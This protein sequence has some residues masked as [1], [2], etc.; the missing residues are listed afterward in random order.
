MGR[1][2]LFAISAA[3][4]RRCLS[5]VYAVHLVGISS[6]STSG[7]VLDLL[8]TLGLEG[9]CLGAASLS[10]LCD[11]LLHDPLGLLLVD[12]LHEHTL[13]L[14]HITLALHVQDM[15]QVLV[16]LLGITVLLE[17]TTEHAKATHPDDTLGHA[18]VLVTLALTSAAVAALTL[19]SQLLAHAVTRVDLGRL[20][21]HKAILSQLANIEA[22]VRH[23]DLVDLIRVEPDLPFP[24]FEHGRDQSLLEFE[25]HHPHKHPH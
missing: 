6:S 25:G 18:G 8:Q 2:N 17:Q 13:V 15:V 23:G 5:L 3:S 4:L 9:L 21:D 19:G 22:G 1:I 14:E 10:L 7:E 16:D 11:L 12:V 24:A 20:L